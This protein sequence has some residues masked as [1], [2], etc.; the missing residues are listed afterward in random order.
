MNLENYKKY[1]LIGLL[2]QKLKHNVPYVSTKYFELKRGSGLGKTFSV[3][4]YLK[5]RC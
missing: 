1:F 2:H 3:S 5:T 4:F